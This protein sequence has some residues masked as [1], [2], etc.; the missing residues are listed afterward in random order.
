MLIS[1]PKIIWAAVIIEAILLMFFDEK[2][3]NYG[4]A[5]FWGIGI[6]LLINIALIRRKI[7]AFIKNYSSDIFKK[8]AVIDVF[9]NQMLSRFSFENRQIL[10]SLDEKN[11]ALLETK[12]RLFKYG[13]F[14]FVLFAASGVSTV[15]K[16][17]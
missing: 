11:T 4:P 16:T 13:I 1:Y 7:S 10:D 15:I 14:C 17:W 8:H 5:M 12:N 3:A 2:V 6:S 9:G